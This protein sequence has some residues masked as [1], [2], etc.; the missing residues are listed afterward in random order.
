MTSLFDR[1]RIEE[2]ASGGS[3]A[4]TAR[5]RISFF[6]ALHAIVARG[7]SLMITYRTKPNVAPSSRIPRSTNR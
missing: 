6:Q 3:G 1:A 4:V 7:N 2:I 5:R